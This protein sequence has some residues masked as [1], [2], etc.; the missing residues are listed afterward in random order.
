MRIVIAAVAA[1][2]LAAPSAHAY[3]GEPSAPTCL[4]FGDIDEWCER[5]VRSY[6]D[7]LSTYAQCVV[8][9]AETAQRDTVRK[10]NCRVKGN[11]YCY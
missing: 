11:S 5:S 1:A 8:R 3:C 9:E 4:S 6:L 10:W 2:F 7:D